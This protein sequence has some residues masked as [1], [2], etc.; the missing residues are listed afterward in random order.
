MSNEQ[1][2]EIVFLLSNGE[3]AF[4]VKVES[5]MTGDC[6]FRSAPQAKNVLGTNWDE[7]EVEVSEEQMVDDVITKGRRTRSVSSGSPIP[8]VRGR[9][10]KDVVAV[11]V[12]AK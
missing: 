7:N 2:Q 5:R 10:S 1:S 6:S 12:R 8:S 3:F 11:Y 4:P 9:N